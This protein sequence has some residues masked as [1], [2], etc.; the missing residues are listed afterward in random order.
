MSIY[1]QDFKISGLVLDEKNEPVIGATITVKETTL[2]TI[3][4][5]DGRFSLTLPDNTKSFEVSYIGYQSQTLS[6]GDKRAFTVVLKES[7]IMMDELVV[8]GYGTTKK[9]NISGSIAKIDAEKLEDRLSTNVG[10][11]IQGQMAGVEVQNVTG[12]PGQE[13]QI[14]VRGSASINADATPLYIIDG[15]PAEDI[16][17]SI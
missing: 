15:I 12:E 16:S 11:I 7:S 8:I 5:L 10:A 3:T 2:G 9:G 17:L 13:L 6:I 1:A 4:G 14:K